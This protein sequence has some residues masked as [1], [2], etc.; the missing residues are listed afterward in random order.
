MTVAPQITI[1]VR[2]MWAYGL[3]W[4]YIPGATTHR[5]CTGFPSI[6]TDADKRR[7]EKVWIDAHAFT[8]EFFRQLKFHRMLP[9]QSQVAVG[10]ESLRL[11]TAVDVVVT[12]SRNVRR[13]HVSNSYV[14]IPGARISALEVKCGFQRTYR[15]H[16]RENMNIAFTAPGP[17]SV[18]TDAAYYQHQLQLGVTVELFR[19]TYRNPPGNAFVLRLFQVCVSAQCVNHA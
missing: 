18:W 14:L 7:L 2:L 4:K 19:R 13:S 9:V 10:C 15:R 11:G 12:S 5:T 3:K 1:V 17:T 16:T 8:R 6:M